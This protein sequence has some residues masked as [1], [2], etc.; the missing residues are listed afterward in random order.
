ML[1][2]ETKNVWSHENK[3][4]PKKCSCQIVRFEALSENDPPLMSTREA[5]SR[6]KKKMEEYN[7]DRREKRAEE[8]KTVEE[9]KENIGDDAKE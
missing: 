5:A 8:K 2:L 9:K 6:K 3:F 4:S 7:K 1:I